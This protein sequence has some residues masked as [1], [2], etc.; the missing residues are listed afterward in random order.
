M[1]AALR[2][3]PAEVKTIEELSLPSILHDFAK[4]SQGFVLVVGSGRTWKINHLGR[5]S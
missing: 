5:Y 3:I 1:S 2:L 4:L